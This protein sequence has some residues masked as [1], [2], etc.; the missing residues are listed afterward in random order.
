VTGMLK[1]IA[2][3]WRESG[4]QTKRPPAKPRNL[5]VE[6]YAGWDAALDARASIPPRTV[7]QV[8][9]TIKMKNP[10]RWAQLQRDLRW[11]GKEMKKMGLNPED[12]R[13][14]L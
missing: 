5:S 7:E 13:Y 14:L 2:D 10:I 4:E 9:A 1:Y 8:R 3:S 11:V 6:D 12:A